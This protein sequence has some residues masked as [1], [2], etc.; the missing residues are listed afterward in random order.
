MFPRSQPEAGN[1]RWE[2]LPPLATQQLLANFQG[3]PPSPH[4]IIALSRHLLIRH[5]PIRHPPP[6]YPNLLQSLPV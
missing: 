3:K 2:A 6:Q 4:P 5:L 1:A